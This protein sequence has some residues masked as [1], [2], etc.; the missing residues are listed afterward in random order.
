MLL[1]V[2]KEALLDFLFPKSAKVL[3]LEALSVSELLKR[4]PKARDASSKD[5]IV[6]CDYGDELVKEIIWE[7]KYS[8]NKVLA[9]KIGT[10][11][12]DVITQELN[13][14]NISPSSGQIILIPMPI[15]DSRRYERGWNQSELI[16]A[17]IKSEDKF[18]LFKYL[19][20]ELV[21][22]R[23]TESQTGAK[24]KKERLENLNNSMKASN[25]LSIKGGVVVLVDDVT[26]TGST[27]GEAR[28]A[29]NE[30]GARKILCIAI[31]H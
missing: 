8:G 25:P 26:T 9:E 10:I 17:A 21:K 12:Y 22:H 16:A 27:F 7:I 18:D 4:L 19:P 11:L 14:R 5:I 1:S 31:S 15:S 30:A 2:I 24:T 20:K 28:R 29:L 13:E 3:A 23:H 6:L